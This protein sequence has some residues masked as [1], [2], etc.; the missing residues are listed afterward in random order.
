VKIHQYDE[1]LRLYEQGVSLF[2]EINWNNESKKIFNAIEQ[3]KIERENYLREIEKIQKE[4][5][6][7]EEISQKKEREFLEKV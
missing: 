6:I 7:Q 1:A 3:V 2:Q 4:T 5:K